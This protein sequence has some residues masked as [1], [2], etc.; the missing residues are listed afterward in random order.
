MSVSDLIQIVIP[1]YFEY[2]VY[3]ETVLFV[4]LIN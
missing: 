1:T 2:I 4:S 3:A